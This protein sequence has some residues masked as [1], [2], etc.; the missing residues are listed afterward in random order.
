MPFNL[1][2]FGEWMKQSLNDMQYGKTNYMVRDLMDWIKSIKLTDVTIEHLMWEDCFLIRN[3]KNGQMCKV[4]RFEIED[5]AS[6]KIEIIKG[7]ATVLGVT[8]EE[9]V[10]LIYESE[11]Q[12]I[13]TDAFDSVFGKGTVSNGGVTGAT[14]I[15]NPSNSWISAGGGGGAGALGAIQ[16]VAR[17]AIPHLNPF[18][19]NYNMNGTVMHDMPELEAELEDKE[20]QL[21]RDLIRNRLFNDEE[22]HELSEVKRNIISLF[23]DGRLNEE[24][25]IPFKLD[26]VVIA[27]GCFASLLN[28][29]PV[30]DIDV[31]LLD[32]DYNRVLANG[33]AESYRSEEP[34]TV[35]SQPP[36]GIL[37]GSVA[38]SANTIAGSISLAPKKSDRVRIGNSNYMENNQIEQTIFFE[39]SQMQYITTKYKTREELVK[40]F[41]FKHCCVSYD[42]ATDKLYI[43]REVYDLIKSKKLVQ[44][45]DRI[46][47]AWRFDKFQERGWKHEPLDV[48][49]L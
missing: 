44:N 10:K 38:G 23:T 48:T 42:F 26:K 37:Q 12:K 18:S 28:R 43:T 2:D 34:V 5:S 3:T 35:F 36:R 1:K 17:S 31:F 16:S 47:A 8:Q 45:S 22:R 20:K 40:H 21:Q 14:Y 33:M 9:V 46:P 49:F 32:D 13:I 30:R 4:T 6:P 11:K 15:A 41:D 27:G 39:L 7:L 29:E 24:K 19:A 25:A